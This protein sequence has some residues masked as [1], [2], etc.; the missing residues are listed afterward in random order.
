MNFIDKK[1][2]RRTNAK[3]VTG[4]LPAGRIP[5]TPA[6][7]LIPQEKFTV[8]LCQLASEVVTTAEEWNRNLEKALRYVEEAAKAGLVVFPEMYMSN[9][10]AQNESR[11]FAEPVL[12][13]QPLTDWPKSRRS[14]IFTSSLG[15]PLWS[16]DSRGG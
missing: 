8:A 14:R 5:K 9:Y 10:M 15:C 12:P 4:A 16:K 11:Y 2:V 13:D 1:E 6:K 7:L 3:I